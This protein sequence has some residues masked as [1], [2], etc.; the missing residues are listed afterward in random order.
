MRKEKSITD[1]IPIEDINLYLDVYHRIKDIITVDILISEEILIITNAL[2]DLADK[3]KLT[4]DDVISIIEIIEL[5]MQK[6]AGFIDDKIKFILKNSMRF[7]FNENGELKRA[8]RYRDNALNFLIYALVRDLKHYT[9][10]P[11]YGLVLSFLDEKGILNGNETEQEIRKR[12][13][14]LKVSEIEKDLEFITIDDPSLLV[15][16]F[17]KK[18]T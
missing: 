18:R 8:G 4:E 7:R 3:G 12:Y 13:K 10:K 6:R 2:F 1:F 9:K 11:H 14:R 16:I 17:Q 15:K 5:Q